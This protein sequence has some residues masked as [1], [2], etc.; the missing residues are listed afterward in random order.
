MK[1]GI[2]TFHHP[3]NRNYG[4]MLQLYALYSV[5]EKFGHTPYVINYEFSKYGKK[6]IKEKI[7]SLLVLVFETLPF[8]LFSKKHMPNKTKKVDSASIYKLNSS[9]DLFIVGSDQV[10]RYSYVPNIYNFFLD[11][12]DDTRKKISY[13][14]SFG[15]DKWTEAPSEVTNKI[16][17]LISTFSAISVRE[18]S[19]INICKEFGK[20]AE[21][22]LDPVFLLDKECYNSLIVNSKL[23]L[24]KHTPYISKMI[25]DT[26][27]ETEH[28]INM[29]SNAINSKIIDLKGNNISIVNSNIK[30]IYSIQQWLYLIKNSEMVI[31]D[32]F[33]CVA[34]CIIFRKNFICIPNYSRGITR[35][36]SLLNQLNI[37]NRILN[38]NDLNSIQK[39]YNNKINYELVNIRLC[40]LKEKSF[41]FIKKNVK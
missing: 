39:I 30:N 23:K 1:I 37:S 3:K 13:A 4:A 40:S 7:A 35:I 10:W 5:L 16:R 38:K 31:T 26:R 41:D 20:E 32:S 17:N 2:L 8:I 24:N 25:L 27:K 22:V 21:L 29:F 18:E 36:E 11:F 33:H 28:L 19:G 15:I 9:I 14:A 34:F 6:S 12:V